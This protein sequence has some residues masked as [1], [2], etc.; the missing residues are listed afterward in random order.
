MSK[1]SKLRNSP[2]LFFR[3]A[4]RNWISLWTLVKPSTPKQSRRPSEDEVPEWYCP[5]ASPEFMA[6]VT[7][8]LPTFLYL[9][10]ITEQSDDLI[11]LLNAPR[12]D[13][14]GIE[15]PFH[16]AA[17]DLFYNLARHHRIV[18]SFARQRPDIWRKMILRRLIPLQGHIAGFVVTFDF[19][20]VM[21]ILVKCCQELGIRTVLIPHEAIVFDRSLYYRDIET[22]ASCPITDAV[23]CWNK[24]QNDIFI[25]RGCEPDR[26]SVVGSLR[27]DAVRS[28]RPTLDHKGFCQVMQ[29]DPAR[30]TV[31]FAC[32]PMD[33]LQVNSKLGRARQLDAIR[34]LAAVCD[35]LGLQLLVRRSPSGAEMT[36]EDVEA[37][38]ELSENV[39]FDGGEIYLLGEREA[40]YHS[41]LVTSINSDVLLEATLF[42]KPT[43]WLRYF[44]FEGAST[45]AVL[46]QACSAKEIAA[47]LKAALCIPDEKTRAENGGHRVYPAE[48]AGA[49][50]QIS[51]F[52]S[53]WASSECQGKGMT[54]PT[55]RLFARERLDV[56]AQLAP[57]SGSE[58]KFLHVQSL[59][60]ANTL[61]DSRVSSPISACAAADVFLQ[62]GAAPQGHKGKRKQ[63][64]VAR[65]L[66]RPLIFAEDGFIRS[67]DIGLSGEAT[68]S[69]ILDDTAAYYDARSLN[70]LQRL[71]N[72]DEKLD[73]AALSRARH[74]ISRIVSLKISKYNHAPTMKLN[75]GRS[76]APKILL[77]DQRFGDQ[78]VSCGIADESS[79]EGMLQHALSERPKFDIII[80]QH[81]DATKGGKQSYLNE[82]LVSRFQR[83]YP[84]IYTISFEVNPYSLFDIVQEVFVVTSGMG[85]EALMAG[86]KV[87]CFGAPFYAGRGLTKD[88]V[89]TPF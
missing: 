76:D 41:D 40:L 85:F 24:E 49:V 63:R 37:L 21:R 71:L 9:P 22:G 29:L 25:E 20:P 66:A 6:A 46:P 52:L 12:T 53:K 35:D 60:R 28:F 38:Q 81:P 65:A 86:K 16:L 50:E 33:A 57:A 5:S 36:I 74:A 31:L 87:H 79:F 48:M 23:L 17:L 13:E 14:A 7:G 80:K 15:T 70:R 2:I 69:I 62:W 88:H 68:L 39:I 64:K 10:W 44:D 18:S 51:S 34:D 75:I 78:S 54:D 19:H 43:L 89:A 42:G 59:L 26:I 3:D 45:V 61:L 27:V 67:S 82:Q 47:S 55:R 77:V 73:D 72:G 32:Q 1:I 84:H 8:P 11:G 58:S 4:I 83:I 30:K 56:V